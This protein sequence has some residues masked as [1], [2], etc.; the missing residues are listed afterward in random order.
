MRNFQIEEYR[1]QVSNVA[2]S[3]KNKLD[4]MTFCDE[5]EN[6]FNNA[7]HVADANLRLFFPTMPETERRS[8]IEELIV[9]QQLAHQDQAN[10]DLIESTVLS[11]VSGVLQG[12]GT[13]SPA[14]FCTYHV[15]S[16]RHLL[17]VLLSSGR[18]CVLLVAGRTL[19]AQGQS[20]LSD[21]QV[22]AARLGWKGT[23]DT[24]NAEDKNSLLKS[25]R[26]LRNGKSLVVYIDGNSG[27]GSNVNSENMVEVEFFDQT[28]LARTGIAFLSH[29][30]GAPIVPA[31]CTRDSG[32]CL[33]LKLYETIRPN[34]EAREQ[35]VPT[36]TQ[37]LYNVLAGAIDSAKGQWE[38]WLYI[39]KYLKKQDLQARARPQSS[40]LSE[41]QNRDLRL[42][43]DLERFALLFF[44]RQPILLDKDRHS[45]FPIDLET[46]K[47]FRTA[48]SDVLYERDAEIG[49]W[50]DASVSLLLDLGAFKLQ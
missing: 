31:V 29:V 18:D 33:K 6:Q 26:A 30:S 9:E 16:Y 38:G 45:F 27:V 44:A 41:C 10:F 47:A 48:A 4:G 24:I 32:R 40:E 35:Y 28:I 43:P 13:D 14:I 12:G 42:R 39:H 37:A 25:L 36:T 46:A 20:Y 3:V 50:T 23:L 5:S 1:L 17:H 15:S 21:A 22:G 8:V 11:D 19:E 34:N 49:G 7:F 2:A